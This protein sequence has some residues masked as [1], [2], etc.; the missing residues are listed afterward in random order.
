[1]PVAAGDRVTISDADGLR[2][3]VSFSG[4]GALASWAV[5]SPL[6]ASSAITVWP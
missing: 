1:V 2:A 5:S 4:P 3:G 6:P